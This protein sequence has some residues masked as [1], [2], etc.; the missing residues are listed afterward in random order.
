MH[1][2]HTINV[3]VE[4]TIYTEIII[5]VLHIIISWWTWVELVVRINC[6]NDRRK[7]LHYI[8]VIAIQ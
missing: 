6:T 1:Y 7:V 2:V 8:I 4:V 3:L 5:N